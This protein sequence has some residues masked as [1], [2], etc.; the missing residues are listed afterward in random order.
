MTLVDV[1][2]MA[3]EKQVQAYYVDFFPYYRRNAVPGPVG[4]L[5]KVIG[6]IIRNNNKK[7]KDEIIFHENTVIWELAKGR[8]DRPS[9]FATTSHRF[10]RDVTYRICEGR[11]ANTVLS[12]RCAIH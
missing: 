7:V 9:V 6:M 10:E 3:L 5:L 11:L 2:S 1:D 4:F 8:V 12:R